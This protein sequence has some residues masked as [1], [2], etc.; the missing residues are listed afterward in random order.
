MVPNF[1]RDVVVSE[2]LEEGASK[3]GI[4]MES[5]NHNAGQTIQGHNALIMV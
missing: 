2:T 3:C 5:L 1:D 4:V